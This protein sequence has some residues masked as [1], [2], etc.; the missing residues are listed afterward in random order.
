MSLKDMPEILKSYRKKHKL[1]LK[2]LASFVGVSE[3][4]IHCYENG[5]RTPSLPIFRLITLRLKMDIR[6][7]FEE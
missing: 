6:K 3:S 2:E 1:T 4:A 7:I 5:T